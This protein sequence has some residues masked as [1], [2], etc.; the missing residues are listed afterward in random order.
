MKSSTKRALSLLLSAALLLVSLVFYATLIRPEYQ[1]AQEL[2]AELASRS[3]LLVDQSST[4]AQ[5]ERLISEYQSVSRLE[6][7]FSLA[8]PEE[9]QVSSLLAQFNAFSQISGLTIQSVNFTYLA[10]KPAPTKLSFSR[11]YGT[12]R[13]D[14]KLLGSYNGFKR[15]LQALETNIRV[16]DVSGLR[17]ETAG[18]SDQ[19]LFVYTLSVDTYY[20]PR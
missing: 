7:N 19:D 16:M 10:L 18:R 6:D 12:L 13:L 17:V 20:Q 2:R 4:I 8:L 14:L 5:V 11:G 1:T 3:V 15:F 9:E